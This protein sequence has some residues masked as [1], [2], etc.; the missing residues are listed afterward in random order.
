MK[1]KEQKKKREKKKFK[2]LLRAATN[3]SK[4]F[5]DEVD[6]RERLE[7]DSG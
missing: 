7:R 4:S 1:G 5:G 3:G 2:Y 6:F